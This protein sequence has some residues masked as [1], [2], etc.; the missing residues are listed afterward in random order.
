MTNEQTDDNIALTAIECDAKFT[1]SL[2]QHLR[3]KL[4]RHLIL[5]NAVKLKE[6]QSKWVLHAIREKFETES[7]DEALKNEA[8]ITMF[9]DLPT[10]KEL[11]QRVNVFKK[12]RRSFS[13]KQ[14]IIEAISEKLDREKE[15]H[16]EKFTTFVSG[17]PPP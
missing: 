3:N 4:K 5:L 13:K 8:R 2:S 7:V 11:N 14:W 17:K 15:K 6:S 9:I 12:F 1:F 16:N 10:L